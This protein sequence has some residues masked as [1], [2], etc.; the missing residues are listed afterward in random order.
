MASV[1]KQMQD[2]MPIAIGGSAGVVMES[3]VAEFL[4]R[5]KID[6]GGWEIIL[7]NAA[8]AMVALDM[9]PRNY[10]VPFATAFAARA[11]IRV[12]QNLGILQSV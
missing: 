7:G 5:L 10:A 11:F 4:T 6:L 3:M 2:I 8:V 1:A 9:L 12:L